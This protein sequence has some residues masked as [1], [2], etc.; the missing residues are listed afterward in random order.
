M[1][2][3]PNLLSR[4]VVAQA[5]GIST[6]TLWRLVKRGDLPAIRVGP[7]RLLI[8]ARD[9]D[10]YINRQRTSTRRARRRRPEAVTP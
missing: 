2:Q 10:A 9:L 6:C 5:L 4:D 3:A 8:D 1:T 7:R